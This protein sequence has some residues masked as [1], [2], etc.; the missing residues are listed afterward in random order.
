MNRSV[1][2][3]AVAALGVACGIQ[4]GVAHAQM[5]GVVAPGTL[6]PGVSV[7][8]GT[9]TYSNQT[10]TRD[11][12][13]VGMSTN[14]GANVSASSTSDYNAGGTALFGLTNSSNLRQEIGTSRTTDQSFSQLQSYQ[15]SASS[16]AAVAAASS[17]DV[18]SLWGTSTE[19]KN[20]NG[21]AI[22]Q[23]DTAA[24]N[25]WETNRNNSSEYKNAYASSY[26]SAYTAAASSSYGSGVISGSFEKNAGRTVNTQT[27]SG[28]STVTT[29]ARTQALSSATSSAN[30]EY[31]RE[32]SG[33]TTTF[34]KGGV[35]YTDTSGGMTAEQKWT[36][37]RQSS[38]DTYYG[39][40]LDRISQGSI[41]STSDQQV[42]TTND[43]T[44][45][46]VGSATN[47]TTS[48]TTKF[49]STITRPTS[50]TAAPGTA[51]ASGTASASAGGS[52][53]SSSYADANSTTFTSSFVQ[54]Y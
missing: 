51:L 53:S 39:Q 48:G 50:L 52:L 31:T 42:A 4:G 40:A 41:T 34:K 28:A 10:G 11:S 13:S 54:A 44:V 45:R 23:S 30:N 46:G 35:A 47:L 32:T 49:E 21:V 3:K 6:I 37:D 27:Q 14:M 8:K 16:S 26:E 2:V 29:E 17:S 24:L 7:S 25:S 20:G 43:V 12:F 38:I 5:Q 9:I 18:T 19:K 22:S 33:S 15:Q 1:F 36:A